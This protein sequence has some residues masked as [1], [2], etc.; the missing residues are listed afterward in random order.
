MRENPPI[1]P[2]KS[3]QFA[4]FAGTISLHRT[5]HVLRAP[6]TD[7]KTARRYAVLPDAAGFSFCSGTHRDDE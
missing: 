4:S 1:G 7:G 5:T 2:V 6:G 3:I